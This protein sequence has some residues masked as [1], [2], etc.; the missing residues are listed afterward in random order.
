MSPVSIEE[1]AEKKIEE[2]GVKRNEKEL[3]QLHDRTCFSPPGISVAEM[4]PDEKKKAM[5]ALL[6]LTEKRD[7][8]IKS[9]LVYNGK[10][11]MNWL[12]KEDTSSPTV[13]MEGIFL[14]AII[15]AKEGRDVLSADIPN[16]FIQTPM[17][18]VNE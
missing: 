13:T 3:H 8:Y 15:D 17:K 7:K 18:W 10:S 6:F 2:R 14:T 16:A 5:E 12:S 4:S 1:M 11:S 9:R